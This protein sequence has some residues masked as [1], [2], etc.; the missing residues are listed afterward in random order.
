MIWFCAIMV[1]TGWIKKEILKYIWG[2]ETASEGRT[3]ILQASCRH[4]AAGR[5]AELLLQNKQNTG[6]A[7]IRWSG[8]SHRVKESW[9]Y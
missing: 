7:I 5:E 3:Y 8:R 2:R 9:L 6:S 4:P 1:Y